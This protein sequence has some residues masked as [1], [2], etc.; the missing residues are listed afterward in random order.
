MDSSSSQGNNSDFL[1]TFAVAKVLGVS[2]GTVQALV[3]R[4]DLQGWKTKGGH[5]RISRESVI[6]Y[7]RKCDLNAGKQGQHRMLRVLVVDDDPVF[8]SAIKEVPVIARSDSDVAI[9][10]S[11]SACA[12]RHSQQP[13]RPTGWIAQP[14]CARNN[15]KGPWIAALLRLQGHHA[16]WLGRVCLASQPLHAKPTTMGIGLLPVR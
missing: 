10:F 1:G 15:E 8:L 13:R 3:E 16:D 9:H 6:T 12:A 2:V 4:G 11:L 14:R 7:Q 5:R